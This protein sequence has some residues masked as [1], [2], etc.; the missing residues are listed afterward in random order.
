[1][2]LDSVE[3]I[4]LAGHDG[5]QHLADPAAQRPRL[6]HELLVEVYRRSQLSRVQALDAQNVEHAPGALGGLVIEFL[7]LAG[8]LFGVDG[9]LSLSSKMAVGGIK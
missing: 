6:E 3:A 9:A 1:M 5:R 7:E 2:S 4:E 8:G